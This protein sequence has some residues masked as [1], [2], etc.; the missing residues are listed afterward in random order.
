LTR[1]HTDKED[2][3]VFHSFDGIAPELVISDD[4]NLTD[5]QN[6]KVRKE[7]DLTIVEGNNND[8]FSFKAGGDHFYHEEKWEHG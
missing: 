4:T 3:F 7:G 1:L 2:H 8:V 5:L 6:A